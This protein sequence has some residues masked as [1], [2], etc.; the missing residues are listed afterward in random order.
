MMDLTLAVP[1]IIAIVS[2]VKT[3]GMWGKWAPFLSI[4]LGMLFLGL[5]GSGELTNRLLEG[6]IAGLTS[7]GLYSGIKAQT[8]SYSHS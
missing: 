5:W 4:A 8:Q 6:L 7:S 1:V 3:A 2:A